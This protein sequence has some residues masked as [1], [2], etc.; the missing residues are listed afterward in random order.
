[1]RILGLLHALRVYKYHHGVRREVEFH[2]F[3]VSS[4]ETNFLNVMNQTLRT[5]NSHRE[6]AAGFQTVALA[7]GR[8]PSHR[9]HG[10]VAAIRG[11]ALL[12]D[13]LGPW[14]P[15]GARLRLEPSFGPPVLAEVVGFSDTKTEALAFSRLDGI[16]HGTTARI[17]AVR[18]LP[19]AET[20][21][22]RVINPLGEPIDGAG[23]LMPGPM[24]QALR[25][26]APDAGTRAKLGGRL[27]LGVRALDAFATCRRGQRLGL[28]AASGVGKSTLL[29]MLARGTDCDVCI[30]ALVGERG[31]ELREF[32]E[33]DLGPDGLKRSLVVCATSD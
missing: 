32:L 13:G 27:D 20:W 25:A 18:G 1:M 33:D 10:T 15:L 23:P 2:L 24:P 17:E 8:L 26:A 11:Q 29:S 30:L 9:L 5:A 21:L 28:F 14:L 19:V 12:I 3:G 6:L 4:Y 7:L 22:G 31:R 16:G